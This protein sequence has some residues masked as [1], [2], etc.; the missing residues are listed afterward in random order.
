M[1]TSLVGRVPGARGAVF[2]DREGEAVELVVSDTAISEYEMKVFGAQL[3]APWLAVQ[4]GAAERGA[5]GLL[6]LQAG[7]AAGSLLCCALPEGYYVVLLVG[8]GS[9]ASP[10]AFQLRSAA[11]EIAQEI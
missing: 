1:L 8:R 4:A 9:P 2:C 3:A 7:C 5:G 10:A 11:A 6:E